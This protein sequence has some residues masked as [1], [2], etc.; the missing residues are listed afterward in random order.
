MSWQAGVR[1]LFGLCI[2]SIRRE[3]RVFA[4]RKR[5]DGRRQVGGL[6]A[7]AERR[8]YQ[9]GAVT[10]LAHYGVRPPHPTCLNIQRDGGAEKDEV[11]GCG[12]GCELVV[13]KF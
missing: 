4:F 2:L 8:R 5:L 11:G 12:W 7:P 3:R 10:L 6:A 13:D 1:L 9:K